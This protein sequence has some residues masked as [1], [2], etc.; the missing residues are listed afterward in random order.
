[1]EQIA[2]TIELKSILSK[3]TDITI[4]LPSMAWFFGLIYTFED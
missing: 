3:G 4:R 2:G 1:V